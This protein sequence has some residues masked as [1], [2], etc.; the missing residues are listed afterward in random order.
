MGP[1]ERPPS[2][3]PRKAKGEMFCISGLASLELLGWAKK[4]PGVRP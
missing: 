3:L 2:P 1:K 4:T